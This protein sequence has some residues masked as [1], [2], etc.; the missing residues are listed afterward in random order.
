MAVSADFR[1]TP[2]AILYNVSVY[3]IELLTSL[4]LVPLFGYYWGITPKVQTFVIIVQHA[5]FV[6][7]SRSSFS[8][9]QD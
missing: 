6:I 8:G 9:I 2:T 7:L 1:T 5:G 3:V 4:A